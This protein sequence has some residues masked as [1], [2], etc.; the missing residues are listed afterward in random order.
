MNTT[1]NKDQAFEYEEEIIAETMVAIITGMSG[2]NLKDVHFEYC[3]K[4]PEEIWADFTYL[5]NAQ[6]KLDVFVTRFKSAIPNPNM[7]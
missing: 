1:A 3:S 5:I 4:S 6:K 7:H 2:H